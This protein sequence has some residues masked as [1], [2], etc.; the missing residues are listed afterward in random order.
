MVKYDIINID[1]QKKQFLRWVLDNDRVQEAYEWYKGY[2]DNALYDLVIEF[3]DEIF[4]PIEYD[5][6]FEDEGLFGIRK[7]YTGELLFTSTEPEDIQEY[8]DDHILIWDDDTFDHWYGI[9]Q[10][11][12]NE[13]GYYNFSDDEDIEDSYNG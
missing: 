11:V 10:Q 9:A 6:T 4:E 1:E 7:K 3:L 8:I 13:F 2:E 5:K 12:I